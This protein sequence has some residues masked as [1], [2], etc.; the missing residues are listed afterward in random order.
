MIPTIGHLDSAGTSCSTMAGE[1]LSTVIKG[2]PLWH[3]VDLASSNLSANESLSRNSS[4]IKSSWA[5]NVIVPTLSKMNGDDTKV[6]VD[7]SEHLI[8]NSGPQE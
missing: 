8:S 7:F 3:R 5:N 6:P 4:Q 2:D 1:I